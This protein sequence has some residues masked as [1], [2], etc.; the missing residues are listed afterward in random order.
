MTRKPHPQSRSQAQTPNLAHERCGAALVLLDLINDF[1]FP[2]G[3]QLLRPAQPAFAAVARLRKRCA[4]SGIPTIYVNDNFG[5]W[6]SDLRSLVRHCSSP[7]ALGRE[8]VTLIEP[9]PADYF[10]LKPQNSGF[11]STVLET[12]LRHLQ[13][14]TL[15]L[16]GLTTD[17]CV[18]FTAHDA[19]LRK[20]ALFV[21][22]D[23]CAASTRSAHRRALEL[24]S[25][26]TK[27][28][29]ISS[30]RLSSKV[31]NAIARP[32]RS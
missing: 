28:N 27:A 17:N 16:C 29:T 7:S 21:P 9:D 32:A 4:V 11:F 24:I 23:C 14:H 31:L 15:I 3:K 8:L 30:E 5:H 12:L 26:T 22:A 1:D 2:D 13:V 20:F 18:L 6:R 10:V 19:Y 25:T